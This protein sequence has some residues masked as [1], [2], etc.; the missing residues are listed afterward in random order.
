MEK[1]GEYKRKKEEGVKRSQLREGKVAAH[2]KGGHK[3]LNK[4]K[5]NQKTEVGGKKR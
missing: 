4:K 3:T 1:K 2:S 5:Q